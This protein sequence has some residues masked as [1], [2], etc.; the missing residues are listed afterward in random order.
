MLAT[1]G[2]PHQNWWKDS[3][4]NQWDERLP[5]GLQKAS[6]WAPLSNRESND[7]T[8]KRDAQTYYQTANTQTNENINL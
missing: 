7:Q 3:T 4:I 2:E 5:W 1:I 6:I 8:S